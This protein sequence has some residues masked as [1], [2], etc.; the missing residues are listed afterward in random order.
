[1]A[2]R[3]ALIIGSQ[4]NALGRLSFLPDVA[5]RLHSLMTDGPGACAGVPLEG[6]P[7]GLLLDPSV[8]ETKDAIDGAIRAAAEAG[9]SLI[10]AYVGH[11]DFQ[12][13]HFFLMPT[14]AQ[15]A[16]SKSAVHLAK[17]IGECLEE[18]PG[19]RGLTVLVD[20]CHAGMGVEQA[21]ASWA[22]F[23]KGL[24]GFE[25]LTATDDQE[26]A[27][28][29]LFR[30]LTEILERGDP[31]AGDR[32]TSRDV[33]R[34]LR[35]AYHPA[36]RAAFNA[37][38]DLG[39]NPAKDPGDV[40]WQDSPGRPQILQRTWY[41]Q[42]TADLGR[43][44][45]ASQ[46]EP[47]VVLAGAAGSGKSTL[48]SA[49]TRPELATGL[50]PE[51]FVQAIGVLLAQT[52]EVGLARDLE[53]QLKRSVPG[54][55]D[56][57]QAFQLAVPDD[58]R[59]RL[60][61][62]SLKVLRPLAYLPESSVVRIILDG[63]D[64]LSQPMRDLMERTLAESPP[65]LR[66]IVTAHPE[67]PGCPPGRRLALEPTDASAL[68]AYLKARDIP[69][70]ARSA[71]LGRAG[72]QWLV[73]TLLADAVIA[74]PGIDL[75][76]LPGTVAEAYAKRLEQTTG[77]SSSEWRDRFGPILA[78]L[79]VA[80][81]GPILPLPLLVHASATLEGPSDEDSVRAAL[82]AL[83][84]LVVRGESGA[85][86]E[87]VGL[88]HAT[89]P[90][91]LL[92]VP[93][94]DSGFE[95]DAPAAHR[96]MIQAID[97]LAPSTKRLLDD[98]LHRYAFLR[99]VHHH[100]MVEDH[101]R[102]Y[103]C[104]YQRESNIPRA[105][106][107]RWEEWVSPFGQRSDTDDPRTL[108]FRS[109][110]AFWTGECGDARGA[111][112]A[113]AALLPDRERAL[114]RDHPDVLTTRGNLAAWTGECGDARGALAAYAALLPDQERALGPDHP[115]TLATLGILGLYAAL[116]GDRPQSCRWL[117]EGLSRAEKRFEPDYPLIK[118]LRNLMEQVGC[119]S[120]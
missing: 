110:V 105:N 58:E 103:N 74:E 47:I 23:V 67:T 89:L 98:P 87:H 57:V 41:F 68:D 10:L 30:T 46:A 18:Y 13:S 104:L 52:T 112:A 28:A 20:A 85:P 71:I 95:I 72:G 22:E 78:A 119:G 79:A 77:G 3:R 60:D 42:P 61:H 99:E 116:V 4:C 43:L 94:A 118:D 59:K 83:G 48:A 70:A 34:R 91:Y 38:V 33:H 2:G 29:P 36:Q 101:A 117:R 1:M 120:P 73:A 113:Y 6:R 81:S 35:A 80:G 50:V 24:S 115:D 84:G 96:A 88:F 39:R 106:L 15:K 5:Q 21:M 37:D 82:D 108:R 107:L 7:A 56:A 9:E 75:A 12:N 26:T 102:A 51:G 16:T 100:W 8:A 49:L 64:Q 86:T 63:F 97:V 17:C 44:V 27:N 54:F 69:A 90:E 32:V 65:A 14:D 25:L 93:A 19:F 114:G 92:S 109:Q 31:E 76:H 66:L 45:A 40:F 111:L 53:T 11:G 62:L 55:A